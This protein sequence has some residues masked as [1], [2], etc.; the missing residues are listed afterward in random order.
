[1]LFKPYCCS[2]WHLPQHALNQ[3]NQCVCVL[4]LYNSLENIFLCQY[5]DAFSWKWEM[6]SN[7]RHNKKSKK[8]K[9]KKHTHTHIKPKREGNKLLYFIRKIVKMDYKKITNHLI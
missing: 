4:Q 2:S 8:K 5:L 3:Q 6:L 9:K 1:M 7:Q